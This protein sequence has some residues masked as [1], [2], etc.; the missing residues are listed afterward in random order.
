MRIPNK[1][2]DTNLKS[3]ASVIPI[4]LFS[5][6]L[7]S[8]C[9]EFWERLG[10]K[11]NCP[12]PCKADSVQINVDLSSLKLECSD[13]VNCLNIFQGRNDSLVHINEDN[14]EK[15]SGPNP[16][17]CKDDP[18]FTGIAFLNV[19]GTS[20]DAGCSEPPACPGCFSDSGRKIKKSMDMFPTNFANLNNRIMNSSE[21]VVF[22][23]ENDSIIPSHSPSDTTGFLTV[24]VFNLEKELNAGL[25]YLV[26]QGALDFVSIEEHYRKRWEDFNQL[27]CEGD[28][29]S[30]STLCNYLPNIFAPTLSMYSPSLDT[31]FIRGN[32]GFGNLSKEAIQ[33]SLKNCLNFG[34]EVKQFTIYNCNTEIFVTLIESGIEGTYVRLGYDRPEQV[35]RHIK[36]LE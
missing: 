10:W 33:D 23:C 31:M 2:P 14:G 27:D 18:F 21:F 12:S 9:C 11:E 24:S 6:F 7:L 32:F 19:C 5:F 16:C 26:D 34:E 22:D 17:F 35:K 4:F 3:R 1:N 29:D 15:I 28:L 13:G 20:H 25:S 30:S 36:L 8:G